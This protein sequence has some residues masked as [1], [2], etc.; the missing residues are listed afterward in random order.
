MQIKGEAAS[1]FLLGQPRKRESN[2]ATAMHGN[3]ATTYRIASSAA[4]FN[5]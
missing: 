1:A 5:E 4:M 2:H 3:S